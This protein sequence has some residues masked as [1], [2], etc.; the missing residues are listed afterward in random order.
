MDG[1]MPLTAESHTLWIAKVSMAT[2][3]SFGSTITT[4]RA[5]KSA[6]NTYIMWTF[7]FQMDKW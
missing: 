7:K 1:F 3:A 2:E 5:I 6:M 4:A